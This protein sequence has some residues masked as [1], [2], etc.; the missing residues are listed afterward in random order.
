MGWLGSFQSGSP[1][2]GT[3]DPPVPPG[4]PG[5]ADEPGLPQGPWRRPGSGMPQPEMMRA[6]AGKKPSGSRKKPR[7][8]QSGG[9]KPSG[10]SGS[11][12]KVDA[13]KTEGDTGS[14]FSN[15]ER[16]QVTE[17]ERQEWVAT[18]QYPPDSPTYSEHKGSDLWKWLKLNLTSE[19]YYNLV[20]IILPEIDWWYEA[21]LE[22][23][24]EGLNCR[25]W[26][27]HFMNAY[28][29]ILCR[30][31]SNWTFKSRYRPGGVWPNP[32]GLT[33]Y[34]YVIGYH[35]WVD[36]VSDSGVRLPID[37]QRAGWPA[38]SGSVA[39]GTSGDWHEIWELEVWHEN[40]V[41]VW[42]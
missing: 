17:E 6:S 25:N 10:R 30:Q 15:K 22:E 19:E 2:T 35:A 20:F 21:G 32:Y 28:N 8:G 38:G 13:F 3:Y 37:P 29:Q 14:L 27:E 1:S 18:K 31:C 40:L 7:P 36:I 11:D 4:D 5:G 23:M 41:P 42:F 39:R 12:G 24:G 16:R 26:R 33:N 34:P 9:K